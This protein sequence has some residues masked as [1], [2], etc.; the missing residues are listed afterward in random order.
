MRIWAGI[1]DGLSRRNAIK[2]IHFTDR[3]NTTG[4]VLKS[5]QITFHYAHWKASLWWADYWARAGEIEIWIFVSI[6]T[7][8]LWANDNLTQIVRDL[9]HKVALKISFL[10]CS[11]FPEDKITNKIFYA[12]TWVGNKPHWAQWDWL[13]RRHA[14]WIVL[15]EGLKYG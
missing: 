12:L 10:W 1:R 14:Q 3:N 13:L 15:S 4:R 8:C 9:P 5:V 11:E 6:L 2:T 7:V